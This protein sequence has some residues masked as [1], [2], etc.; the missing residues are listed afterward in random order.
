MRA[1]ALHAGKVDAFFFGEAFGEGG[2]K[3]T[4]LFRGRHPGGS[5]DLYRR[6]AELHSL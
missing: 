3:H 5:R 6:T 4:S 2:G 1:G